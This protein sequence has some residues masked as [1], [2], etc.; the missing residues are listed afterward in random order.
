MLSYTITSL[1]TL[2]PLRSNQ[3]LSSSRS[4]SLQQTL[5]QAWYA[6]RSWVQLLTPI[7]W[8][9]RLFA[10]FRRFVLQALYQGRAFAVPLAV[11]GN[12]SVGGSGKTPLIIGM[13]RALHKRGYKVAVISR[14]Y[15]GKALN[16]PLEVKTDTPVEECGDEPLLLK[17]QLEEYACSVV[18][19]AKRK[20][21][22]E[23]VVDNCCCDLILSDD[24]LQH[25]KLHRDAEIA[26][27]DGARAFGNGHCLPAGPLREPISRLAKVDFILTNGVL[28]KPLDSMSNFQFMLEPQAFRNLQ[29][30][31]VVAANSW[32]Y[33][34]IVHAVAAIGNPQRFAATLESLGLEVILHAVDDHK[35]LHSDLLN[36]NDANP[37]IITEKDAVKLRSVKNQHIWVLET[38]LSLDDVFLDD[39]LESIK[40]TPNREY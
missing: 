36:F 19:D 40:L 17:R 38:D 11:I 31:E 30:G 13:V 39:F 18:V 26:V 33:S 35:P 7:A 9:F 1:L 32:N 14:G 3:G 8:L 15:G 5:V 23:F 24:G 22:A 34:P 21:A 28:K 27:I 20:R 25:Y 2:E 16:Y 37:V 12:I 10:A 4:T 29:S 6:P